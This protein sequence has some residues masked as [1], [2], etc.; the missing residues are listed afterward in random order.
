M[1]FEVINYA[2]KIIDISWVYL[3]YSKLVL[4]CTIKKEKEWAIF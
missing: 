3:G 4:Y 2:K 1:Y